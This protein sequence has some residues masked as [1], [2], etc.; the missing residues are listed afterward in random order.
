M[1]CATTEII[2]ESIL[3]WCGYGFKQKGGWD[4]G[5]GKYLFY[6]TKQ[7]YEH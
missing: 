5:H 2:E 4:P 7:K 3:F 1:Q 6:I